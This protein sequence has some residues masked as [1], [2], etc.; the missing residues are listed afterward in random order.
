MSK[1]YRNRVVIEIMAD[2]YTESDDEDRAGAASEEIAD[3]LVRY[4]DQQIK[5]ADGLPGQDEVQITT[6]GVRNLDVEKYEGDESD[7]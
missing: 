7:E 6:W 1:L 3:D 5:M 4:L 2:I